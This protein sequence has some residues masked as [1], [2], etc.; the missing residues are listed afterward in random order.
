[1]YINRL[2]AK[3][4]HGY[5]SVKELMPSG[6]ACVSFFALSEQ[7]TSRLYLRAMAK[8]PCGQPEDIQ[9]FAWSECPT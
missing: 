8:Q 3:L 5:G 7:K 2:F 9:M 1:M 4:K 6:T